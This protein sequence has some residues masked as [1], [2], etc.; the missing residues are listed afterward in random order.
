MQLYY[1]PDVFSSP[2]SKRFVFTSTLNLGFIRKWLLFVPAFVY[3]HELHTIWRQKPCSL[4]VDTWGGGGKNWTTFIL[5]HLAWKVLCL[6]FC[7]L[8]L[9]SCA[10]FRL[11]HTSLWYHLYI[12]LS[13]VQLI[14]LW[15]LQNCSWILFCYLSMGWEHSEGIAVILASV[16]G[17]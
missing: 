2:Q 8:I 14:F 5:L 9:L 6:S 16:L 15:M 10:R 3:S 1:H 17:S 13:V 11:Y 4:L 12:S 7:N